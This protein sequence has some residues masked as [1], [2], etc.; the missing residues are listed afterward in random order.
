[1]E[2]YFRRAEKDLFKA[3]TSYMANESE[4]NESIYEKLNAR[5]Q[6]RETRR[7][8]S[9]R[10]LPI[11]A[12]AS[13]ILVAGIT[14]FFQRKAPVSSFQTLQNNSRQAQLSYLPDSSKV[15]LNTGST[16]RYIAGFQGASREILLDG[17]AYFEVKRNELKPF[18]VKSHGIKT[19]VLGT[20]FNV[21]AY[22]QMNRVAVTVISGKVGVG[23]EDKQQSS[24]FLKANQQAVYDKASR[25]LSQIDDLNAHEQISWQSGRLVFFNTPLPEVLLGIFHK[26][27]KKIN[28]SA[29]FDRCRIY[30]E[31]SD[32]TFAEMLIL[33]EKL[34]ESKVKTINGVYQ[35]TGK[36]CL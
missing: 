7:V 13:I 27:G 2:R 31:L 10:R 3:E 1:M 21:K 4:V 28:S 14:L 16:I 15:W 20:R 6:A 29:D 26:Y 5:I 22:A 34:T 25:N 17:E 12:A 8:I 32:E 18:V 36:G 9:L 30:F 23:L 19:Q 35:L 11:A 24:V 33:L